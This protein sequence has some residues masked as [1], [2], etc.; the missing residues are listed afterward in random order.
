MRKQLSSWI[1]SELWERWRA[2]Q[3]LTTISQALDVSVSGIWMQVVRAGGVAPRPRKR[4]ANTLTEFEREEI[5]RWLGSGA[6]LRFIAAQLDRAPST[7]S[8]EVQRNGGVTCYRAVAAERRACFQAC[9]PQR[10]KLARQRR[11]RRC[12][13]RKLGHDWSPQQIAAWL[14]L[15][16]ADDA[17]MQVSHETIYR[18]LYV[19]TRG[20]LRKEL[21]QHLRTHRTRRKPR[22]GTPTSSASIVDG[23]S[24]SERPASAEDR[25]VPGHWEGDLLFGTP[26]SFIA[27]LVERATRFVMLVKIPSKDTKTVTTALKKTIKRLPSQL[28]QSLTWDRGSELSAHK[29]LAIDADIDIFFC[30]PHSP[31]Q[32]GSNE[33]TNGL[34]RQYFPSGQDVSQHDQRF[35]D[36]IAHK[37]NTR[38]RETLGWKTPSE[39]LTQLLQ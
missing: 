26:S 3:T 15:T 29:Q 27:T 22:R 31:W 10:C 38:P 36:R 20:A 28:R 21:Q 23:I 32:R 6:S 7:I 25:A 18:T 24:I 37:L 2:G 5:S 14:R 39:V 34:L 12:V 35:L 30:D 1:R 4:R 8:R 17:A 33:N 13:A 16:F 11:L 19:Q 9:R